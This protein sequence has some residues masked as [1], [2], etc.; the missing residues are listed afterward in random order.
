[1]ATLLHKPHFVP[2]QLYRFALY[3]F[4]T[5]LFT[6]ALSLA[7][8]FTLPAKAQADIDVCGNGGGGGGGWEPAG[9][10]WNRRGRRSQR[11]WR[12]SL[13]WRQRGCVQPFS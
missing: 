4:I 3:V 12:V 7:L 6:A 9:G 1:M 11:L 10:A 13:C 2:A 5:G 8:A